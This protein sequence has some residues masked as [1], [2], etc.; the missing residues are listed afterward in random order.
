MEPW[1]K[2]VTLLGQ[3]NLTE[4]DP[5][6]CNLE[7]WKSYWRESGVQGLVI[8]CSGIVSYYHSNQRGQYQAKTLTEDY[9]GIWCQA[10][11]EAGLRVIARMDIHT[12]TED[13]YQIHPNWYSMGKD[14][15]PILSQGRYVAC[16]N[17]GYYQEFV[18]AVLQDVICRYNP[19]GFAD[20]N[21]SGSDRKTICYCDNCRKLFREEVGEELPSAADWDNPVYR[22]WIRWGY[23]T[24]VRNWTYFNEVTL[25]ASEGRCY[26]FGML[27]ADPFDTGERFYDIKKLVQSAP[28]IFCDQ[29]SRD[30]KSSFEQNAWSGSLLNMAAGEEKMVAESMAHYYKGFRTFRLAS[31][32]GMETRKWMMAGISGGII[33]WYHFVGGNTRD[34]RKYHISVDLYQW[35][36]KNTRYLQNR[37]N[38]ASIGLVWNQETAIYYGRNKALE[39]VRCPFH[40]FAKALSR[41]GIPF[42]PI[43]ADDIALYSEQLQTLILPEMAI[44]TRNQEEAIVSHLKLGKGLVLSGRTGTRDA[45][46]EVLHAVGALWKCLGISG[47]GETGSANHGEENWMNHEAHNYIK[48]PEERHEIFDEFEETDILPF[49]GTVQLIQSEGRLKPVS[50]YIPE[51]PIYPPEFAWIREERDEIGTIYAGTMKS[52]AKVVYF[53]ADIDRMY[54]RYQI[55]DHRRLLVNAVRYVSEGKIPVW[56]SG[57]GHVHCEAYRKE[58]IL[59]IHLVNLCGCEGVPGSVEEN[60]PTGPI[61]IHLRAKGIG[62]VQAKG[63]VSEEVYEVITGV[64]GAVIRIEVLQEQEVLVVPVT[65]SV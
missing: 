10:A 4:D 40:G 6:S 48:L 56:I 52:G 7:F 1:Y 53:A 44:L 61:E 63:L 22:K 16:V 9:F 59:V 3:T 43:H 38:C 54:G 46:G 26:W 32:E 58:D 19:D 51:F 14:G 33:P 45:E 30:G 27:C 35:Y 18:P 5:L 13:L 29:Q 12:T 37:K 36:R 57:I 47:L 15:Q 55:P 65:I 23:E 60:I 34:R 24:R 49:G 11:K 31:A 62:N 41:A 39:R 50:T 25:R 8:N 20:N 28:F 2:E 64:D 17:G 21:W 42:V